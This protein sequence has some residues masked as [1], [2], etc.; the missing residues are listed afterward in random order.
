VRIGDPV[1]AARTGP[2]EHFAPPTLE[3]VVVPA[4]GQR[5]RLQAALSQLAEQ[6]PL[7]DLR[8][9]D[10]RQ[11]LYVSLYGEVQKEVLRRRWLTTTAWR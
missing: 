6:D 1:G 11:E 3:T 5:G 8:Q 10:L 7:I 9:D 2:A 4:P